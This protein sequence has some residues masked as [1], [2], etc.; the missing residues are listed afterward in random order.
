MPALDHTT[1]E[2][3]RALVHRP[4]RVAPLRAEDIVAFLQRC[5]LVKFARF[6]PPRDE[7]VGA[8]AEVRTMIDT[9]TA[10]PAPAPPQPEREANA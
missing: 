9:A 7:A 3:R 1:E 5:D 2:I 6:E 10:T 4:D 8:I